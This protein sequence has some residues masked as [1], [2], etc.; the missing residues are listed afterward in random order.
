VAI[1]P[2][3]VDFSY[4]RRRLANT[5][6]VVTAA[7]ADDDEQTRFLQAE[8][9]YRYRFDFRQR[10]FGTHAAQAAAV[11]T[12]FPVL[13]AFAGS[14]DL[15]ELRLRT[16][17]GAVQLWETLLADRP[18][19]VLR[20]LTLYRLGWAYHSAGVSGLPRKSGNEAFDLLITEQ[21][22]SR[23]AVLAREAKTVPWKSKDRAT[24]FSLLPGLGQMYVGER[25]SG[26]VRLA[27]AVAAMA[28]VMVPAV[29]GYQRRDQLTWGR[30]WRLLATGIGGFII[31]SIDYTTAY[32]D[33]I[34][35][36]V[37]F[38][39]RAEREFENRYPDSP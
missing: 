37:Q 4:A 27:V 36:V 35:G 32:Q 6:A 10:S 2:D 20:P 1:R 38:N 29:V 7:K 3:D 17:D 21:P 19:T 23:L 26:S 25:L 22:G 8:G 11:A 30:D 18:E 9:L 13:Q 28:M 12:E 5:R 16:Y 15:M 24:R 39:E 34:R 33:A 31:L 14:L